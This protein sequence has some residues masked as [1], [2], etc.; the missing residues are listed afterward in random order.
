VTELL[1]GLPGAMARAR[2]E[3]DG[4]PDD[5]VRL[6]EAQAERLRRAS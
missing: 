2:K 1:D 5:L 6:V 4:V 3:T